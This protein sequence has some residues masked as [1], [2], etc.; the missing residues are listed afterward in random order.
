MSAKSKLLRTDRGKGEYKPA[1]VHMGGRM[2]GENKAIE[3]E[4]RVCMSERR[5]LPDHK[6]D[7]TALG[8]RSPMSRT[9]N[10]GSK[11]RNRNACTPCADN[12]VGRTLT[13]SMEDIRRHDHT[14]LHNCG[15]NAYPSRMSGCVDE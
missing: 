6:A 13:W 14:F 3:T 4:K 11:D 7:C 5:R 2:G 8:E 9:P 1:F 12:A 10:K 15:S